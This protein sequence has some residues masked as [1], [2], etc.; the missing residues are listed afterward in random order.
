[1]PQLTNR[2]KS[3]I[4]QIPIAQLEELGE[5]LLDFTAPTDLAVWFEQY[6]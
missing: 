3:R 2:C 4:Q 6:Q 1:M 5:A